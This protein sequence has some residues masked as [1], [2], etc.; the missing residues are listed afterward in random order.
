MPTEGEILKKELEI[1][2]RREYGDCCQPVTYQ[3]ELTDYSGFNKSM[4][5]PKKCDK[6]DETVTVYTDFYGSEAFEHHLA[7]TGSKVPAKGYGIRLEVDQKKFNIKPVGDNAVVCSPP[8]KPEK[9]STNDYKNYLREMGVPS[10]CL[11][12]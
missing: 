2:S 3:T 12:F 4:P 11:N 1:W 10:S 9:E 8:W 7:F 5:V 6:K